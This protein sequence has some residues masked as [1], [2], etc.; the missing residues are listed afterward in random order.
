MTTEKQMLAN[1]QNAL[2][3]TG[4]QTVEGKAIVARNAIKHGI[5][6]RDLVIDH[7]KHKESASEYQELLD[8]L[9]NSLKPEGQME[10]LLV[11]KITADYWRLRRVLHF[12]KI[13]IMKMC[14][15]LSEAC[16]LPNIPDTD[17]VIRY[18]SHLQRSIIQNLV[19]LKKLQGSD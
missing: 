10:W 7:D 9:I 3:S 14:A 8:G 6:T 15:L 2:L 19:L 17:R 16:K 11:E 1:Q 12:E 5:F 13:G 4:A 18:E